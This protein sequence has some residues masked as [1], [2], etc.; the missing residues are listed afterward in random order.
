MFASVDY[1]RPLQVN[2]HHHQRDKTTTDFVI[3]EVA[4]AAAAEKFR[5]YYRMKRSKYLRSGRKMGKQNNP[6]GLRSFIRS[7]TKSRQ[8]KTRSSSPNKLAEL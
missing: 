6:G 5:L 8:S 3:F 1:D 2:I 7:Y 4:A